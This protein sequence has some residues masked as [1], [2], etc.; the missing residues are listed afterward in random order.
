M[1]KSRHRKLIR[2][3]SSNERLEIKYVDSQ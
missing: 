1:T 3:T 2:E